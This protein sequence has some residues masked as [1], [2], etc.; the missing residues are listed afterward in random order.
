MGAVMGSKLLKAIVVKGTRP[1]PQADPEA[2]RTVG[3]GDLKAVGKIDKE[4]GW[5][6]QGTTG[7]LAWC[8]EVA[9]LPV[10]NFRKTHHTDAWKIDGERLNAARIAT[11]GC[12]NC[13]MHC[14]I[15]IYDHEGRESELDY[16]NI[17]L[18][19]S[20]LEIFDL[21]QVGSLN[22]LCD[23]YGLDTMSAGCV[24]SFYAD[25]IEHEAT[26]G[27]FKFGD[28]ERAKELLGMAARRE[29]ELGNLLADG[30]LR[31]ARHFGHGSEAYAMQVKGLEV[32]AYN[33]KF[34]PGQALAFGVSAIGAHHREAWII[35]FE[36][37]NTTRESYGPE[38]AAKVI[39]LQRIRGGMF[40]FIVACRFPWIELGWPLD[41]YPKYF[42]LVTGLDWTLDDMWRTA[43]RIYAMIKLSYL[44]EYPDATREGDYPPGVWFDPANADSDGPIAGKV[45]DRVEYDQLLQHYYDQRGYDNRG[46]PTRATLERL[47]LTEEA[48]KA[49]KVAT[50]T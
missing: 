21:A 13:T 4:T 25:A 50:L 15:T 39:E 11:Y 3:S 16:E 41:H 18:L 24:L 38:K 28:A 42:N 9:A 10:K 35:T 6:I 37:K 29:G 26:T 48:A 40:E 34:I 12:P 47:G 14:G 1:L 8:N 23:D 36:L 45:L 43:D 7:V 32:A 27:D 19:G 22:Y 31:M 17:G 30:S 5:S 33:C 44:R 46:I 49:E 20:N 2:M